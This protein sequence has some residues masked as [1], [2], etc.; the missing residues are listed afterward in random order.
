MNK[1]IIIVLTL[2]ALMIS[3]FAS[4]C[5]DQSGEDTTIEEEKLVVAVSILPQQE[6]VEKIA[7]NNINVVVLI[8]PGASPATHEP[9]AG[10][11][12]EVADAKAY[13]TVGSGLPFENVWLDKIKTVNYDMRIFDCSEGIT[14]MEMHEEEEEHHDMEIGE[15]DMEEKDT[16]EHGGL[17]PHIWT[18]PLNAKI[19]VENTYLG[20]IEIDP[21]NKETYLQNKEAYLKELDEA[22]QRIRATLG[23]EDG[24]FMTYHPS[25][26]YFATEYGLDMIT[27]E[28]EGKE[29]SPKDMQRLIDEAKE[30]NISVIF[31]QAQ[32]STQSAKAIADA[33]D[34]QVVTVDP[35]AKDY[36]NNLDNIAEAFSQSIIKE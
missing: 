4:G 28:E 26:N 21:A 12:R 14:I 16:H 5:T 10:Q 33:I 13:F 31:V 25:W 30:K 11:L 7:G 32:F 20:L 17:D 19:M 15:E 8:P 3:V 2:L 34:G 23:E 18:S 27:I 24:S 22:D 36:I 6:F 35:L 1:N 29:P 9:T